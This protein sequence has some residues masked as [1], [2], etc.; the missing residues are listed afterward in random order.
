MCAARER[1]DAVTDLLTAAYKSC[2]GHSRDGVGD[3][4]IEVKMGRFCMGVV[5]CDVALW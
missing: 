4:R 1:R 5:C 3:M 2:T